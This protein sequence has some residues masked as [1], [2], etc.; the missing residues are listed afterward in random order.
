[1]AFPR[2]SSGFLLLGETHDYSKKGLIGQTLA[3]QTAT[4]GGFAQ[5]LTAGPNMW[6]TAVRR[7]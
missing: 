1:M 7:S 2:I 6:I 3:P 4:L 5:D